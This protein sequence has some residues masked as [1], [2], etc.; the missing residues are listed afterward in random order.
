MAAE[1]LVATAARRAA[2]LDRDGVINVDHGYVHRIADFAFVP[3]TLAAAAE[4][5]HRGLLLVVVTNQAGIARGYYGEDDFARLTH[6]MEGRFAEA[7]APL[8]AVYHCPHHATE[9]QGALR[10]ACACRKPAPGMFHA[11]ARDLHVDLARSVVFGD[12]CDDMR[13]GSAAGVGLRVL[14]GKDGLAAP[15]EACADAPPSLRFASLA[16][17][18]ASGALRRALDMPLAPVAPHARSAQSP[19]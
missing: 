10:V 3:G 19:T 14:L 9:G 7:G 8:A 16:E 12:K 13:A 6:W 15:A 1:E 4:L 18:V 2:F 5:A 11:A 17:A